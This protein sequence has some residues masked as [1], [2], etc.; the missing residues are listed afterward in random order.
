MCP[1]A[2]CVEAQKANMRSQQNEASAMQGLPDP[3]SAK[4]DKVAKLNAVIR[5]ATSAKEHFQEFGAGSSMRD[6]VGVEAAPK[7][8]RMILFAKTTEGAPMIT[9]YPKM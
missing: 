2:T 9:N 4:Q 5:N 7:A 1:V 8:T 6:Q 3:R